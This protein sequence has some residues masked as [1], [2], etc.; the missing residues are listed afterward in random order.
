MADDDK[1]IKDARDISKKIIDSK[2]E[3]NSLNSSDEKY[4][5][6]LAEKYEADYANRQMF[7]KYNAEVTGLSI[8]FRNLYG[9]QPP[10]YEESIQSGYMLDENGE[11]II[12]EYYD[13]TD[14]I[15]AAKMEEKNRFFIDNDWDKESSGFYLPY[16]P[17]GLYYWSGNKLYKG[18]CKKYYKTEGYIYKALKNIASMTNNDYSLRLNNTFNCDNGL[19]FYSNKNGSIN[20]E[21][22]NITVNTNK[23][24]KPGGGID[25]ENPESGGYSYEISSEGYV[26]SVYYEATFP[27]SPSITVPHIIFNG[28]FKFPM[29]TTTYTTEEQNFNIN[30]G[31]FVELSFSNYLGS[32]KCYAFVADRKTIDASANKYGFL[33]DLIETSG[34]YS[35][36][37]GLVL[38]TGEVRSRKRTWTSWS[39]KLWKFWSPQEHTD[40]RNFYVSMK[41]SNGLIAKTTLMKLWKNSVVDTTLHYLDNMI[42]P[43]EETVNSISTL[44]KSGE[45][46]NNYLNSVVYSGGVPISDNNSLFNTAVLAIEERIKFAYGI[47]TI[48][49]NLDTLIAMIPKRADNINKKLYTSDAFFKAYSMINS[50]INKRSGTLRELEKY[51]ASRDGGKT[52]AD[53]KM[54]ALKS[55]GDSYISYKIKTQPSNTKEVQIDISLEENDDSLYDSL[56]WLNTIYVL[57]DSNQPPIEAI[58]TDVKIEK[59]DNIATLKLNRAIPSSYTTDKNVRIVKTLI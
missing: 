30:T 59:K 27:S 42:N 18:I 49:S 35:N 54:D 9:I 16:C 7:L 6:A 32:Y 12:G 26:P 8:E 13:S 33:F 55:Y 48:P 41:R 34:S 21:N 1:K 22:Y 4:K 20:F 38:D 15:K 3:I 52:V 43:D 23:L 58:I 36:E 53:T 11:V 44:R 39:W 45:A 31:D 57:D 40:P 28:F 19:K 47:S 2:E 50:R 29:F 25:S 17:P 56:K 24:V 51:I 46:V 5:Q 37:T 10:I 14:L